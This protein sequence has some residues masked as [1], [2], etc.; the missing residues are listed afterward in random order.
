VIDQNG[1]FILCQSR[2]N[3][4]YFHQFISLQFML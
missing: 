4:V 3:V 2:S 1:S